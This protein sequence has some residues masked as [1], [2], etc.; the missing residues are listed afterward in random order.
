MEGWWRVCDTGRYHW[1]LSGSHGGVVDGVCD[2][3]RYHW[4]LSRSQK[5]GGGCVIQ[6]DA[7][8]GRGTDVTV[9]CQGVMEG[10]GR[11]GVIQGDAGWGRGTDVTVICQGVMEGRGR[12]V[13]VT[14][15]C[16]GVM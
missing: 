3:G 7:G 4:D 12:K 10:R 6:G 2:T 9:I 8:W 16:P 14:M 15:T 5:R 1:G 13:D 11:R